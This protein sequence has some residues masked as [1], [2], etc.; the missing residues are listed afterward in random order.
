MVMSNGKSVIHRPNAAV[1]RSA[2]RSLRSAVVL[3]LALLSGYGLRAEEPAPAP[4]KDE[5]SFDPLR[6][7]DPSGR[8]P[9]V[10]LPDDIQNPERWR[11]IPEGRLMPGNIF[12]RFLVS[13][14]IAPVVFFEQEV[15][16][17]GGIALTDIDFRTQRRQEFAQIY[18][19]YTTEGQQG[20]SITWQ[21]WLH[22]RD[23]PAG[24]VIQEERSLVRVSAGFDKPL[25][26]RFFG[27]GPDTREAFETSYSDANGHLGV[28][29]RQSLPGPGDN[30]VL[31]L[32]TRYEFHNLGRGWATHLPD[33]QDVFTDL[34]DA[35]DHH[36]SGWL[37]AGLSYDTRD[38]Q[39][40]PYR[41]VVVG[42]GVNAA[43]AQS[44]GDV[45]ALFS[46]SASGV[47]PVPPLFHGGGDPGEEHPP[48][49][50]VAAGAQAG[51]TAGELPFWVLPTLGGNDTLRGY[52][53]HRWTDRAAWHAAA[54][55]RF[56]VIPRGVAI[57]DAIRIERIGA[58]FFFDVGAV[59]GSVTDFS[60]ATVRHCYGAG[61][62]VSLERK[63]LFRLDVGFSSE[64][65]NVIAAYGLSF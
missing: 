62:R 29:L 3:A 57:T 1:R 28:L 55:Y 52:I 34:F 27:L 11:Y 60:D 12:E 45:G 46:V 48:T 41:G 33:T 20:Y 21:R 26:L 9:K 5:Q 51:A 63:A 7:L 14:F 25:T 8:I 35:A 50:T 40:N 56:W 54:E 32:G 61:L 39:H 17:G 58:A 64:D 59:A 18:V 37:T 36:H 6:G 15:G 44:R 65:I 30:W 49:D 47:L 43:P 4:P 31:A 23:M 22:Q 38:S 13:S 19:S 10:R 53:G 16:L 2:T 42:V 24:G